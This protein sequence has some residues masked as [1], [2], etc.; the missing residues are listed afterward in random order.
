MSHVSVCV[1]GWV[2]A[3]KASAKEVSKALFALDLTL[4]TV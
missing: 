3:P 4:P 1:G 2:S